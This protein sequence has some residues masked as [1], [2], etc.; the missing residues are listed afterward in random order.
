MAIRWFEMPD[1]ALAWPF[2]ED[3]VLLL[4]PNTVGTPWHMGG[5]RLD[6]AQP[7]YLF[8]GRW[9]VIEGAWITTETDEDTLGSR[10]LKRHDPA[11]WAELTLPASLELP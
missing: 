10:V 4:V 3:P 9:D 7:C 5:R 6:P 8:I 1:P 2:Y 11:F